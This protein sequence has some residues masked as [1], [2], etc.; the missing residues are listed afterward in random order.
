MIF[1]ELY[2][3]YYTAVARILSAVLEGETNE[4]QLREIAERYAFRESAV[5][6]LS[7]LK[8][9]R[10][11]LLTEQLQTPL[12]HAPTMPITLLEQRWLKSIEDDPRLRLFGVRMDLP[13]DVEPLFGREDYRVF[14]RY[15][16]GDPYEDEHYQQV[17]QTVLDAL[18]AGMPLKIN[19]L[20]R[21]GKE[22]FFRCY[23]KRLEYS[24]K[25]DKFRLITDGCRF[26]QVLNLARITRCARCDG[27]LT[28]R[29]TR[30]KEA[31]DTLT[32]E[33]LDE[34]NALERCML[35][36]AHFEKQA[37]RID[38]KRYLL[39]IRYDCND[40]P[41]MVIRVLS[42]GSMVRVTEPPRMVELVREKLM[43]QM[44][45]GLR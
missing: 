26:I 35:Q 11:Q 1:N 36:F 24:E 41:E 25:D 7:A 38:E 15:S 29:P 14:D 45:C 30:W 6:I 39:K 3:A 37:E 31:Y 44:E 2:S 5:N 19:M 20:N 34:R 28:Y 4:K 22:I 33:I 27:E 18:R 42:F 16:D 9:G 43:R 13:Q 21:Q 23:P 32:L 40:E 12:R 17:F 8:S 10:W